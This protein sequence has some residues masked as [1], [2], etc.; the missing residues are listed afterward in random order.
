[1]LDPLPFLLV[2]IAGWTNQ[3]QLQLIGVSVRGEPSSWRTTRDRRLRFND[4]QRR[5]L[6]VRAN[7]LGRKLLAEVAHSGHA[8]YL[9]TWHRKLIAQKYD[10]H[11][12]RGLGR[13]RAGKS[14][15]SI[16]MRTAEEEPVLCATVR[17]HFV[18]FAGVRLND[19]LEQGRSVQP[20]A[21]SPDSRRVYSSRAYR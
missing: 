16:V 5:R 13:P 3:H 6:A 2:S 9:L 15:E 19:M 10:G 11:E 1:M 14:L 8:Q 17:K 7:G 12:K 21:R 20:V 4:E 18:A